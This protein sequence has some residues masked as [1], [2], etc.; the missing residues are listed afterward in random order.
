MKLLIINT[1]GTSTKIA[2]FE[3]NQELFKA[4]IDH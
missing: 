1:G 4:S 3:D 2:V